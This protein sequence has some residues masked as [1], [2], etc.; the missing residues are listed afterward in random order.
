M[1]KSP[2]GENFM[3]HAAD[4][5]AVSPLRRIDSRETGASRFAAR[6]ARNEKPWIGSDGVSRG[7]LNG[8]TSIRRITLQ[9]RS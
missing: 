7:A 6:F 5:S 3:F 9:E 8:F 4:F 2:V 1:T